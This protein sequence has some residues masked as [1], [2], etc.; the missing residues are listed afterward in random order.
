MHACLW[1][2]LKHVSGRP[3]FKHKSDHYRLLYQALK[4]KYIKTE[5]CDR[6]KQSGL[7][8]YALP[9][10][11]IGNSFTVLRTERVTCFVMYINIL[12][13]FEPYEKNETIM[14]IIILTI[15]HF[16]TFLSINR[17]QFEALTT[18]V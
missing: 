16:N 14:L 4:Q 3:S 5:A 8:F 10:T 15:L 13:L 17:A 1:T 18:Q 6:G 7:T 2:I 9:G 12:T 11:P